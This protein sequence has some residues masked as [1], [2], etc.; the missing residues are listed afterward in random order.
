M[1]SHIETFSHGKYISNSKSGRGFEICHKIRETHYGNDR[2]LADFTIYLFFLKSS[3]KIETYIY[4]L[5][6]LSDND[7]NSYVRVPEREKQQSETKAYAAD[8]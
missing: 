4:I 7:P 6:F 2:C 3:P 8:Y 1:T 5:P